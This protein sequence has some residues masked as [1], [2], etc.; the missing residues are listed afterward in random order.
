LGF[1]LAGRLL[2]RGRPARAAGDGYSARLKANPIRRNMEEQLWLVPDL[3]QGPEYTE[4]E[5]REAKFLLGELI[6]LAANFANDALIV[7]LWDAQIRADKALQRAS[8][9]LGN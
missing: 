5:W 4:E 1:G 2:T 6:D 7:A 9:S 8:G 3:E